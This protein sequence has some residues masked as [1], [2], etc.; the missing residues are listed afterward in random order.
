M[1]RPIH[2]ACK[3]LMDSTA[4]TTADMATLRLFL[5]FSRLY[6]SINPPSSSI[7]QRHTYSKW[8]SKV[9]RSRRVMMGWKRGAAANS[10]A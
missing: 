4:D 3:V 2:Y 8:I 10:H 1:R 6:N 9:C 5:L 7:K